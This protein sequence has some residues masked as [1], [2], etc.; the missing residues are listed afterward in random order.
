MGN[1]P[2]APDPYDTAKSQLNFNVGS[3]ISSGIVNNPNVVGPSGS[4]SYSKAGEEEVTMPDGT[5]I[6]VPR[7]T[8]TTTLGKA[9]QA[10]KDQR[11]AI[12]GS[13]LGTN[14]SSKMPDY[15]TG[16]KT[17]GIDSNFT[18]GQPTV[19]FMGVNAA[20]APDLKTST[21]SKYNS[22]QLTQDPNTLAFTDDAGS[23]A[24]NRKRY[25][26]AY[27]SRGTELLKTN[28][29]S[30]VARLAAMGLAPGGE[31][32][33]RVSDQFE[34]SA[35]DLA[36]Q[37][38]LAGGQEF[39]N[40][41]AAENARRTGDASFKNN[42]IT[43][44]YGMDQSE[45]QFGNTAKS[46]QFSMDQAEEQMR[47]SQI[48]MENA[49]RAGDSDRYNAAKQAHNAAQ[50]QITNNN[51]NSATFNNSTRQSMINEL[52]GIV[53]GAQ[54][55]SPSTPNYQGQSVA[56]PDYSGLVKDNYQQKVGAYNNNMTG[57]SSIF[58]TLLGAMPIPGM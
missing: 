1:A 45:A 6:K 56:A 35:N 48:E 26:D 58:K 15:Q 21:G 57:I 40:L 25:E 30:E 19:G 16:F 2:D 38:Q 42:A 46:R 17:A 18:T 20:S 4:T 23:A 47:L 13:L 41:T 8:Q 10:Q 14:V 37:A 55:Q 12:M 50:Q 34:K 11:D 54:V 24:E 43:T 27:A 7:Y 36:I 51:Q 39:Q 3:G 5:K 28:R 44:G 22:G 33:G 29:D 52:L 9:E 53:N 31:N 49:R 32:Y